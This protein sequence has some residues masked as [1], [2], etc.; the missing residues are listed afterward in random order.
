MYGD[1]ICVHAVGW[2]NKTLRYDVFSFDLY[3]STVLRY[4]LVRVIYFGIKALH[5]A[6]T[7]CGEIAFI[8]AKW[9]VSGSLVMC[10]GRPNN[11]LHV[12][13]FVKLGRLERT[14]KSCEL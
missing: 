12:Y 2:R 1:I 8:C 13:P 10:R 3:Q 5:R 9:N 6:C 7:E 4:D 14:G 11:L